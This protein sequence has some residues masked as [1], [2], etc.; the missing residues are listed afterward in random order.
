VHGTLVTAEQT[1]EPLPPKMASTQPIV[2]NFSREALNII[3]GLV[4][5]GLGFVAVVLLGTP[6]VVIGAMTAAT[7]TYIEAIVFAL[8]LIGGFF[9]DLGGR[10]WDARHS[11]ADGGTITS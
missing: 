4:L 2:F 5:G 9:G 8:F 3:A 1:A 10:A 11:R 7:L 6:D